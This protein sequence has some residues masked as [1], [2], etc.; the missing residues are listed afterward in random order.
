M[1]QYQI[2]DLMGLYGRAIMAAGGTHSSPYKNIASVKEK[3]QAKNV[4]NF[5]ED[6]LENDFW[7]EEEFNNRVKEIDELNSKL[8]NRR[9]DS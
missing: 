4:V 5:I 7:K 1:D 3:E 6:C 9:L 8:F 2:N